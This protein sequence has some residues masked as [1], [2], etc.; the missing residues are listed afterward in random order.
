MPI[1]AAS[2]QGGLDA[3]D[4][5][6]SKICSTLSGRRRDG[7]LVFAQLLWKMSANIEGQAKGL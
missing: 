3:G 4:N 5:A 2:N 7:R 6:Y 1:G